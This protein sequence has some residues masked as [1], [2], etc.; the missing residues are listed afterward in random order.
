VIYGGGGHNAINVRSGNDTI[1]GGPLGDTINVN[2]RNNGTDYIFLGG[3]GGNTVNTGQGT[4][5]V[6]AQNGHVDN[7][8]CHG[9][10]TVYAD[11]VDHTSGCTKVI[12]T[13]P[14]SRDGARPA[15]KTNAAAK[16]RAHHRRAGVT[17]KAK[18]R[19]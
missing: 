10:T 17:H 5:I 2:G 14:P 6:Y 9:N 4:T 12:F 15:G 1:Y 3:G 7:I 13:P 8:S 18:S 19:V 16:A 11:R